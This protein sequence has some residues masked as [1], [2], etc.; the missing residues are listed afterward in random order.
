MAKIKEIEIPNH[1]KYITTSEFNK[2]TKENFDE[3]LKKANLVSKN[4]IYDFIKITDFVEKLRKINNIV[5]SNKK[6]M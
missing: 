6:S 3:R 1:D 4:D 2:L 5:N